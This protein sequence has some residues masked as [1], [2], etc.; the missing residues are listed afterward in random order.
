M[1]LPFQLERR[2]E[3]K[4][5]GCLAYALA[6][7][8]FV[9]LL[10]LLAAALINLLLPAL[11]V[12]EG[13]ALALGALIAP[14]VACGG[15]LWALRDYR[16]R[17]GWK[18]VIYPDKLE[19]TEGRKTRVVPFSQVTAVRLLPAVQDM[20]CTLELA[21][22]SRLKLNRGVAPFSK[23]RHALEPTLILQLAKQL[24]QGLQAGQTIP[25]RENVIKAWLRIAR[26]ACYVG[27][28][29]LLVATVLHAEFGVTLF[30]AAR[31][32]IRR[33]GMGT[34]GGFLIQNSGLVPASRSFTAPVAWSDLSLVRNDETG[35]LLQSHF[36]ETFSATP[37]AKNFWPLMLLIESRLNAG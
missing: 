19:V 36:G 26:G 29:G 16:R 15:V 7:P 17:A 4:A 1:D 8:V 12:P 25:L 24:D 9:M 28:A 18:V 30:Q 14:I 11:G 3:S 34:R 35:I 2:P 27:L 23:V 32:L 31:G 10:A 37:E 22:G 21:D 13:A 20:A 6:V 33:G 5:L